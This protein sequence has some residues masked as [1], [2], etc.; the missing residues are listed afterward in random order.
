MKGLCL[1]WALLPRG[2]S[3]RIDPKIDLYPAAR[4][5]AANLLGL[6]LGLCAAPAW[7][8]A[9]VDVVRD[10]AAAVERE[11][12]DEAAVR[13]DS[14][15][16]WRSAKATA[17]AA[18]LETDDDDAAAAL[19]G[20]LLRET[21]DPYT[22]YVAA[23]A[24]RLLEAKSTTG[25][26]ARAGVGVQLAAVGDGRSIVGV[27]E[28]SPASA[29]LRPGDVIAGVDGVEFNVKTP[30]SA[31]AAALQGPPGTSISV[32]VGGSQPRSIVLVRATLASPPEVEFVGTEAL[33]GSAVGAV[34]V[35]GISRGTA[36]ALEAALRE[37]TT[38][39]SQIDTFVL[40]LRGN[41]GGALDGGVEAAALFM[42][43]KALIATLRSR[44]GAREAQLS[45]GARF[46]REKLFVL[47]DK[48]TASAAELFTAALQETSR[49]TVVGAKTYGKARVQ[50]AVELPGGGAVL[51]SRQVY[52]TPNGRDLTGAG[53]LPDVPLDDAACGPNDAALLCLKRALER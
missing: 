11:F 19:V 36:R 45:P 31:V 6:G 7:P 12:Y 10:V 44:Q 43:Q 49:A 51:V 17:V 48:G 22:R 4:R 30:A 37:A 46:P 28:G 42:P 40:D 9:P 34:R 26:R 25:S 33:P 15:D 18:A 52:E 21:G 32:D 3:L 50:R 20:T 29:S 35:R 8:T 27:V 24:W 1:A 53:I 16:G 5:V 39:D 47:V 41:G 14:A 13:G 23:D 38:R 2:G